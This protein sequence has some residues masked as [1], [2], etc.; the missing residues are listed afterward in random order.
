MREGLEKNQ[1]TFF[2][3]GRENEI[4]DGQAFTVGEVGHHRQG[5]VPERI[6]VG[7]EPKFIRLLGLSDIVRCGGILYAKPNVFA[8]IYLELLAGI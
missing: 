6:D 5:N 2:S 7:S 4:G 3:G 8:I 1:A